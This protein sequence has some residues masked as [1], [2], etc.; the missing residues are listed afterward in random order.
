MSRKSLMRSIARGMYTVP[1]VRTATRELVRFIAQRF[2]ISLKNRW[3]L[4]NFFAED[5]APD[6][7]VV[8]RIWIPGGSTVGLELD[9]QD[10]LSRVWYYLGY[11]G[12][13]TGTTKVMCKL[14]ETKTCIFDI[15][16]NIGYYSVLAAAKLEGRGELHCFEPRE[17]LFH[18]LSRNIRLN[19]FTCAYLNQLAVSDRDGQ[20]Y[21][22]IPTDPSAQ[23]NASLIEGFMGMEQQKGRLVDVARIDSYCSNRNIKS[24]DLLKIDVEGA[25]LQVLQGVGSILDSTLP[26]IILE[27]LDPYDKDLAKFFLARP[28]RKFLITDLGLEE[29]EEIKAHPFYRDYY[30]SCAP[31]SF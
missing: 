7:E 18:R 20:A 19:N 5:T 16:A 9:V 23:S 25:E 12:Y 8:S 22:L 6:D 21:L 24:I 27:V 4:H 15:G 11:T 30:L 28:Y 26:D 31:V 14:L 1:G 13:E 29:T 2:P 10:Y 17:D 3:R